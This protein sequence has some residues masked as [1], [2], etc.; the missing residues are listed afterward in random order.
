MSLKPPDLIQDSSLSGSFEEFQ[1]EVKE[2]Q[3]DKFAGFY[4]GQF[5]LFDDFSS[6]FNGFRKKFTLTITE[7]GVSDI[8]SLRTEQGS[9]LNVENNLFIYINDILQEPKKGLHLQRIKSNLYRAPNQIL[10]VP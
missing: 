2:V 9:D 6:K 4:P 5:I 8:I 1:I 3:T 7:N 10:S